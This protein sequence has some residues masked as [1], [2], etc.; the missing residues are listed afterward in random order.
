MSNTSINYN[1]F[2][3]QSCKKTGAGY[4]HHS[5]GDPDNP[6]GILN[7]SINAVDDVISVRIDETPE[8]LIDEEPLNIRWIDRV[9]DDLSRRNCDDIGNWI[10]GCA[11]MYGIPAVLILFLVLLFRASRI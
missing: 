4:E 1:S 11:C 5:H 9:T 3:N 6:Q 7:R 2:N 10:G 8:D